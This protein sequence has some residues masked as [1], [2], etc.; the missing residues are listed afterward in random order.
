M[1]IKK[2]DFAAYVQMISG[3]EPDVNAV[4]GEFSFPDTLGKSTSE[5]RSEYAKSGSRI[6]NALTLQLLE[7]KKL[8]M[9]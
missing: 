8:I 3:Q 5:W 6:H 7:K 1:K 2:A 9:S 4:T